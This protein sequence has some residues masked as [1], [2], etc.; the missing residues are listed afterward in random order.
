M[1][2][3]GREKIIDDFEEMRESSAEIEFGRSFPWPQPSQKH[4]IHGSWY[5]VDNSSKFAE[6][7]VS[8]GPQYTCN[9]SHP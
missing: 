2:R 3:Q 9:S 7:E 8:Y 6:S 4:G 1:G 5:H